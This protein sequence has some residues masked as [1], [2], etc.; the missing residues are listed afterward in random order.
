MKVLHE[1][2]CIYVWTS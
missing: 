1:V 2:Q